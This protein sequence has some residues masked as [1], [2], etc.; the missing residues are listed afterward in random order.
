M[1][2]LRSNISYLTRKAPSLPITAKY[3]AISGGDLTLRHKTEDIATGK[4]RGAKSNEN[5]KEKSKKKLDKR[6]ITRKIND[7]NDNNI[8][9]N[10]NSMNNNNNYKSFFYFSNFYWFW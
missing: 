9:S 8:N 4:K 3:Q 10:N 5:T 7:N 6:K 1:E 2:N